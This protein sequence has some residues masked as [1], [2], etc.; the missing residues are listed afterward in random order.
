MHWLLVLLMLVSGLF[1]GAR[2]GVKIWP[3]GMTPPGFFFDDSWMSSNGLCTGR[4]SLPSRHSGL[5]TREFTTRM[6]ATK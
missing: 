4:L 2:V 3:L 1:P 5:R 6:C